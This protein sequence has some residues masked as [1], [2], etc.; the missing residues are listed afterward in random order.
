MSE[1]PLV[2]NVFGSMMSITS[3][4]RRPALLSLYVSVAAPLVLIY[5]KRCVASFESKYAFCASDNAGLGKGDVDGVG[6]GASES[7]GGA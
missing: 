5:S 4:L 2:G 1:M 6:G 3:F 7:D